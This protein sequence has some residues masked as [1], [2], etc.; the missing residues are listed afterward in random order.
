[1]VADM[2]DYRAPFDPAERR[3]IADIPIAELA[4]FVVS[5]KDVPDQPP[6]QPTMLRGCI[7]DRD[8]LEC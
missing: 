6:I 5:E 1:M 8:M 4:A 3:A 2:L 7:S